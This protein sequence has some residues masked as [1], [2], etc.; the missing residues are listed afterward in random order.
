MDNRFVFIHRWWQ[1][2]S[3]RNVCKDKYVVLI[4]PMEGFSY[5][6]VL[7]SQS[8]PT[9]LKL[10]QAKLIEHGLQLHRTKLNQKKS[11]IT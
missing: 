2:T 10:R 11:S 9:Y 1:R 6:E 4:K 5:R 3:V 7:A 8:N